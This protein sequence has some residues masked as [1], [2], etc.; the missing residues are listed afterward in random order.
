MNSPITIQIK[1]TPLPK[2]RAR[3]GAHGNV[4][5]PASTRA[6]E[7]SIGWTA[8]HSMRGQQPFIGPVKIDI[9]FELPVPKSWLKPRRGLAVQHQQYA[10]SKPD[11]DNLVKAVLDGINKVVVNDDC[12][13]VQLI[14]K[15]IFSAI[16]CITITATPLADEGR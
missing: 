5:T 9:L 2:G 1:D 3:F 14:A 12:Q 8:K 10:I 13:I 7:Q 4:Y 6:Y 16:P 11:I 15:K